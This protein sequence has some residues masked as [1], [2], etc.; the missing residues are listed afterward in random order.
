MPARPRGVC[1]F[2]RRS[3][4]LKKS[5]TPMVDSR[6]RIWRAPGRSNPTQPWSEMAGQSFDD[7]H[8]HKQR[9]PKRSQFGIRTKKCCTGSSQ[10]STAVDIAMSW[11]RE[12][13]LFRLSGDRFASGVQRPRNVRT[14]LALR[15]RVPNLG[16]C[17]QGGRCWRGRQVASAGRSSCQTDQMPG[18]MQ[19]RRLLESQVCGRVLLAS[20]VIRVRKMR[21]ERT[22]SPVGA[23]AFALGGTQPG[24]SSLKIVLVV[25]AGLSE[26]S[27]CDVDEEATEVEE[28]KRADEM[29]AKWE[30]VTKGLEPGLAQDGIWSCSAWVGVWAGACFV[31]LSETP[32]PGARGP[33]N[34]AQGPKAG[35]C[36]NCPGVGTQNPDGESP[37]RLAGRPRRIRLST[38]Q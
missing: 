24:A 1:R 29:T 26:R 7:R 31:G 36:Q 8:S 34:A 35:N 5:A 22:G 11:Y 33:P 27:E 21:N 19:C 4:A 17:S 3:D 10:H 38:S 2:E 14:V 9:P 16:R 32:R 30:R 28:T 37:V 18:G 15:I 12:R 20:V 23:D 13:S 6:R 25:A